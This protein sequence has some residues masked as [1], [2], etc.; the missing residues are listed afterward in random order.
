MVYFLQENLAFRPPSTFAIPR[1]A[2]HDCVHHPLT[3]DVRYLWIL[4]WD[5]FSE[6]HSVFGTRRQQC[7]NAIVSLSLQQEAP[8]ADSQGN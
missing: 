8:E 7:S 3:Q 1:K 4:N 2:P 6:G 5:L